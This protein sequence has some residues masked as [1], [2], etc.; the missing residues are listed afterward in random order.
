M[1]IQ[2]PVVEGIEATREIRITDPAAKFVIVTDYDDN[3][4]REAAHAGG[5]S[6][7]TLKDNLPGLI[8]LLE[9]MSTGAGRSGI[10]LQPN[11]RR[12]KTWVH[13]KR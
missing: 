8:H 1:N 12:Y 4:L 11:V 3:E 2:M 6:D 13:L 7:Y 9:R 10:N 5:A